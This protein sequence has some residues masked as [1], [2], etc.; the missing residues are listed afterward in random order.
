[1]DMANNWGHWDKR[2]MLF[3]INHFDPEFI[4]DWSK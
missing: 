3:R 4:R 1:M 2:R